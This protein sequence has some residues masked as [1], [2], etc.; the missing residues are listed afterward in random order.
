LLYSILKI[1]SREAKE[2]IKAF[3]NLILGFALTIPL[4]SLYWGHKLKYIPTGFFEQAFLMYPFYSGSFKRGTTIEIP[5]FTL[6]NISFYAYS[7]LQH[8]SLYLFVLFIFALIIFFRKKNKWKVFFLLNVLV[9][10]FILTFISVK[11][12]RYDLPI[13]IFMAII[14]AWFIDNLKFKY[15]KIMILVCLVIFCVGIY[16]LSSWSIA[17]YPFSSLTSKEIFGSYRPKTYDY[18]EELKKDGIISSIEDSLRKQE[19]TKIEFKGHV[20]QVVGSLYIFFQDYIFNK[21][22]DIQ[23]L[24]DG[25]V[26]DYPDFIVIDNSIISSKKELLKDYKIFSKREYLRLEE[27]YVLSK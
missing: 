26:F 16:F 5:I 14:T 23:Q 2:R 19:I 17:R 8:T 18:I 10:Y 25:L 12:I 1:F 20:D 11:Q 15:L 24:K 22:L 21:R 7:L 13:L 4:F 3:L 9:P 6:R 27:V